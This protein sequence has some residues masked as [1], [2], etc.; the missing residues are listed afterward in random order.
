VHEERALVTEVGRPPILKIGYQRSEISLHGSQ[1]NACKNL[2]V[3][4][5]LVDRARLVRVLAEQIKP[6]LL[7]PRIAIS[8]TTGNMI[9]RTRCFV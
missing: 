1:I 5:V 6:W 7:C 3:V 9:E 8:A 4:E 2:G